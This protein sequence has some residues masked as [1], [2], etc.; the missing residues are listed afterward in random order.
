MK[1]IV[2]S[3]DATEPRL[4]DA[5][6]EYAQTRGFAVDPARVRSPRDKPRVE[7][8]VQY[9]RSNF[10]AGE[11]FRDIDD[12]RARAEY[13]CSQTAGMRIHGTTRM[14]PAEVFAADETTPA[15]TCTRGGVRHPDLE[16]PQGGP[17]PA[18]PDRQSAL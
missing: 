10:F 18:R 3:A 5:F 6:R 2:A 15:Q 16:T 7:R 11:Y 14:R 13:W 9:V 4:N 1:A 8:C 17:G 12:C